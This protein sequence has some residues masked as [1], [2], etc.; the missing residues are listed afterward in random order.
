MDGTRPFVKVGYTGN[1]DK[2][3][4][5]QEGETWADAKGKQWIYKN[6]VTQ[7]VTPLMDMIR[8]ETNQ[9]CS[10][11]GCEIRWRTRVDEKLHSR[12]GMCLDCLSEEETKMRISGKYKSYERKKMLEN[13]KAYIE[14]ALGYLVDSKQYLKEH[15]VF[16]YVNSNGLVEE[17][18]G[19][20]IKELMG[21]VQK[22]LV[23]GRK[24]LKR[25]MKELQK[26][27]DELATTATAG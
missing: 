7:T 21:K 8:E 2:Y 3:L 27:E 1:V 25:V 16:T 4:I 18:T 6:G 14:E 23:K 12:T 11:C 9:K 20:S 22:D 26:V 19:A 5:R 15:K 13:E 17:W 10:G 24:E